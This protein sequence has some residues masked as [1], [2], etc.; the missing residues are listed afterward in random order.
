[1]TKPD[2]TEFDYVIIGAGAAGCVLA[3]RLT[4]DGSRTICLLE[5]GPPDNNL[6]LRI[7][8]GVYKA[9][10]N[11]KFAWQYETEPSPGTA[12]RAIP[13]PQGRVLGGSTSINGMNYNRGSC[14][15]F[16][17]WA[18]RGN[19]GWSYADVLPYFKRTE[20]RVGDSDWR[21]RGNDGPL[22]ITDSDWHHP[23]CNAFI[24]GVRNL[25][26]P[27]NFDYNAEGQLGVGYYQR[28][29]ERGWRISASRAFLSP[30]VKRE[31]LQIRTKA[32]ATKIVLE[33][34]RA[35]EVCYAS[36]HEGT[37]HSVRARRE[38]IL[39]AGAA[40]T[41]KL[42]QISGIGPGGLLGDL[43]IPVVHDLAGVGQNLQ[44]HYTTHLVVSVKGSKTIN[45]HGL[46][47]IREGAR[48]LLGLPS[49]LAIGPSLVYAFANSRDFCSTPD[50][51]VDLALGNCLNQRHERFPV[52]RL[53]V[54]QLRP[55]STGFIR[56]RSADPF[57]SPII[58]PNYLDDERDQRA[59]IAGIKALRRMLT[60]A[61]LAPYKDREEL[62]S[63]A[64]TD[65]AACLEFVRDSGVTAYHLCGSCRMGPRNDPRAVVDDQ[66]RVHGLQGL[67]IADASIMPYVPSA[68][69]SAA[70]FMI[71]EKAS[72][73]I[74]GRPPLPAQ[75]FEEP[76]IKQA[77]VFVT[78]E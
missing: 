38:V 67:R 72:D 44:D 13:M 68:N 55:N 75:V 2:T 64:V 49:I 9:S 12:G 5:A 52:I 10:S 3:N 16:D 29:I 22:A 6:L 39:S 73:M 76:L 51:Q 78:A 20:R 40:N 24:M 26:L 45:G 63:A 54:Y 46:G 1:V 28:Y 59:S 7:P 37:L 27:H 34:N 69:T 57:Q 48:W 43:G 33:G 25:G 23:I 36:G 58:Q 47:L 31:N 50:I 8:A 53:G 21:Y 77:P 41:P 61:E 71:A 18:R 19:R 65:D 30:I 35:V 11:S 74:L 70:V 56:A 14:E 32:L 62:P 4:A 66:L 15:D 17:G 60:T 42:L